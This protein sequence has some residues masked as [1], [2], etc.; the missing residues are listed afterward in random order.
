MNKSV[1]GRAMSGLILF[2]G[3]AAANVLAQNYPVKPIRLVAPFPPGG[4]VDNV[5]RLI[6][7]GM[8]ES[9][10]QNVMIDNRG[11]AS[12]NIG[13][14]YVARAPADG[15]TLLINT[16]PTVANVSLFP[17]LTF[18][19]ERD[20]TPISMVINGPSVIVV[21]PSLPVRNIKEFVALAR[22]RPGEIKYAS[23]GP[24]TLPHM[25]MELLRYLT[26][27]NLA[28][29]AYKGGGPAS[30]A[31]MSGEC[32]VSL[33]SLLSASGHIAS[34]RLRAV[35]ATGKTRFT[36]LPNVPTVAESGVP[37]YEFNAWVG[38]LAPAATP[39]HIIKLLNE[40]VVRA[41]RQ[42]AVTER[43]ARDGAEVAATTPEV[44]RARISADTALW[45]R[46]I[47]ETGMRAE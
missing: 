26:K 20:F 10:G 47:R 44:F 39:Q 34:G 5:A 2:A 37:D 36:A 41:A 24:G 17:K 8:S 29:I 15:Y 21:H 42:P 32:D 6:A 23:S 1:M 13:M 14:E 46:V 28:H 35:A 43:V 33:H 16:I 31:L 45:A 25:G 30:V 38:V 3:C 4:S 12:G 22:A 40:H 27:T 7:P 18:Q 19:P 9:L 11:G